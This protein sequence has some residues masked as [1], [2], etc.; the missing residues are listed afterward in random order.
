MNLRPRK[1]LPLKLALVALVTLFITSSCRKAENACTL[2]PEQAPVIKGLRLGMSYDEVIQ[3]FRVKC[4]LKDNTVDNEFLDNNYSQSYI[5]NTMALRKYYMKVNNYD[6]GLLSTDLPNLQGSDAVCVGVGNFIINFDPSKFPEFKDVND[7]TLYFDEQKR[8]SSIGITYRK[9][10]SNLEELMNSLDLSKWTNWEID[11]SY[12]SIGSL[13]C[14]NLMIHSSS[15]YLGY[16]EEEKVIIRALTNDEV[17]RVKNKN[18]K[19]EGPKQNTA[20]NFTTTDSR[21]SETTRRRY[22]E[23]VRQREAFGVDTSPCSEWANE[24]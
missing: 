22:E 5:K 13:Y 4:N 15:N 10:H 6:S 20:K 19:G 23:C 24:R 2:T 16:G 8:L 7:S 12:P 11:E 1:L 17:L 3:K 21:E 18:Y 9:K 14:S